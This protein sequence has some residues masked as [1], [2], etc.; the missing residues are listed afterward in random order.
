MMKRYDVDLYAEDGKWTAVIQSLLVFG[1]GETAE[2]ALAIAIE[3]AQTTE[4]KLATGILKS[5]RDPSTGLFEKGGRAFQRLFFEYGIR[6]AFLGLVFAGAYFLVRADIKAEAALFRNSIVAELTMIRRAVDGTMMS[7][8]GASEKLRE[9]ARRLNERLL[10][11]AEELRPL[12]QILLG[13]GG[14][15]RN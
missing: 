15:N 4:S 13:S 6:A 10:P 11:A 12:F 3:N 1:E 2:K 9:R 14:Q 8:E 7:D 5:P